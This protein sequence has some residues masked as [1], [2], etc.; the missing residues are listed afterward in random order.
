MKEAGG[1]GRAFR[2]PEFQISI[3]ALF[4]L[5][6][7]TWSLELSPPSM[8][9]WI[10]CN[11]SLITQDELRVSPFD[12]GF[13][14]GLGLFETILA[15]DGQPI[16]LD[17]HLARHAAGCLRLGWHE[18]DPGWLAK[19]VHEVLR[20]NRLTH[21]RA[22]VRLFQTAGR[23]TLAD[24]AQ[25]DSA[26]TLV[27]TSALMPWP[28]TISLTLSPWV[29]NERSPLAGLKCASYAENLLALAAAKAR[30]F[31][32][33]LFLN[34]RD[35]ICESATANVFIVKNGTLRTPSLASGCLPGIARDVVL[36]LAA[37]QGIP[38]VQTS[39]VLDDL[40]AADELLL[41][42]ALRGPIAISRFD[43]YHFQEGAITRQL[44]RAWEGLR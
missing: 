3:F 1:G 38:S 9:E 12:R 11:G 10:W 41:T 36:S 22:R 14:V 34:T 25:G 40:L 28:E 7:G 20:A 35:E 43:N 33:P 19:G 2:R 15:H 44:R 31:D 32:E 18:L 6:L 23:G 42:S 21:G 26:L 39:L 27:T 30:G 24:L 8:A 29:R 17:R 37:E 16:F 4:K 5:E 13:T